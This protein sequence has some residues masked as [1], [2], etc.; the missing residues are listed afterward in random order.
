[1][2]TVIDKTVSRV[3]YKKTPVGKNTI[4][5]IMKNIYE[6]ELAA[7]GSVSREEFDQP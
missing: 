3:W 2:L 4:N 5:T 1:L 7:E 6:R